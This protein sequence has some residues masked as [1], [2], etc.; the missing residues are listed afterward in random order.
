MGFKPVVIDASA[1]V[2]VS[3]R[4][5]AGKV[6]GKRSV[7]GGGRREVET[8]EGGGGHGNPHPLRPE[9]EPEY[10]DCEA[11]NDAEGYEGSDDDGE[12]AAEMVLIRRGRRRR[13]GVD[14]RAVVGSGETRLIRRRLIH[15]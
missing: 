11:E 2:R 4:E 6:K 7:A 5:I 3:E 9:Y 14:R 15:G 13:I 8:A 12:E 10:E 1:L